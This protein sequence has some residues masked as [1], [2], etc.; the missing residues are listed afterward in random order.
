[1][2]DNL[3]ELV[4][5][6]DK[7][8]S[9]GSVQNDAIGGFNVFLEAQ[10]KA[11]GEAKMT[12]VMF[13]TSFSFYAANVDVQSV[14]NFDTK[15]Y[16]PNGG[17]AL[18]DA[19]G[20]TIDEI[21]KKLAA[22]KE[23][24]RPSKVIF[25]IL[26]DGEE[27]SSRAYSGSQVKSLIEQQRDTYKWDFVFLAAG[28][29]AFKESEMLGM[30]RGKTMNFVNSGAT[31]G[32]SYDTL[33][34]YVSNS[35]GMGQADYALYSASVNLQD[36]FDGTESLDALADQIKAT[37]TVS[38]STKSPKKEEKKDKTPATPEAPKP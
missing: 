16:V 22:M 9:M 4:V 10:K 29:E 15:S 26:T 14:K 12:V 3:T 36:A 37:A 1:V 11:E 38:V 35:R 31:Q 5:V 21:G 27:N 23:E 2:K 18:Y 33:S 30:A 6:V 20:K 8:G 17:T 7:S 24:D 32:K 19:V 34:S 28:A 13:D 25:A